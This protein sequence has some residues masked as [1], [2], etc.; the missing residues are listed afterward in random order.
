METKRTRRVNFMGTQDANRVT[1]SVGFIAVCVAVLMG[2]G[3]V[4]TPLPSVEAAHIGCGAVVGPR[5]FFTLD[6]DVGPCDDPGPA[7]TVIGNAVLDLNGF[8]VFCEDT[9]GNGILPNGIELV[10]RG[11]RVM[12]GI[13]A[14]CQTG[15][16]VAGLGHHTVQD[17]IT[18]NNNFTGFV[19]S[20]D[21]N[22]LSD[23]I[24]IDNRVGGFDILGD[25]NLL[26]RNR[27]TNNASEGFFVVGDRNL[28]GNNT[29]TNNPDGFLIIGNRNQIR[30]NRTLDNDLDGLVILEGAEK[31]V[32]VGNRAQG[33]NI[34]DLDDLNPGC[35]ANRW[36]NNTFNSRNQ[37][38]IR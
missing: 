32:V 22:R 35:D 8:K 9:N 17:L 33:N 5:G 4:G 18:L 27:S 26:L 37:D 2:L 15:V 3:I 29:A 1:V 31:N 25:N 36:Q 28:L 38:C 14:D 30:G 6:A 24:A 10:G 19:V 23:N 13:I 16:L 21:R 20:S 11:A 34:F 7:L 12:K